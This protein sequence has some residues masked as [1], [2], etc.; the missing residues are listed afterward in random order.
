MS[1]R[2]MLIAVLGLSLGGCAVYDYDDDYRGYP[3]SYGGG[4]YVVQQPTYYQ[5]TPTYYYRT[6]RIYQPRYYPV[7]PQPY[8]PPR[9]DRRYDGRND[10]RYDRHDDRH[11]SRRW[12]NRNQPRQDWNERR[13]DYT[14]RLQN[15]G[16]NRPP[17]QG[18]N[19]GGGRPNYAVPPAYQVRPHENP[20]RPHRSDWSL[21]N[22]R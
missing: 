4:G 17:Q 12:D 13:H 18:W 6:E 19:Q 16:G 14:P 20:I 3:R 9:H 7:R 15:W 1:Y 11:D 21:Q 22:R 2:T 8:Q 10:H 5:G